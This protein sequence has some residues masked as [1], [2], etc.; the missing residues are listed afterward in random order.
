MSLRPLFF[1][2]RP[3]C[4]RVEFFLVPLLALTL[5]P[6]G[7]V[8]PTT[9][10]RGARATVAATETPQQRVQAAASYPESARMRGAA[11]EVRVAFQIEADGYPVEIEVV[12]SSGSLSLDRAAEAA[13]RAAGALPHI[14]GRVNV[15]VR[16]ALVQGR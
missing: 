10:S 7:C 15:P 14:V 1:H 16:F 9:G 4:L 8:A 2:C 13:V 3:A 11:G 6:A 12:R 5:V